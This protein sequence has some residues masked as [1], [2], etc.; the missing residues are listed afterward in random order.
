M[1]SLALLSLLL[2]LLFAAASCSAAAAAAVA[3]GRGKGGLPSLQPFWLLPR[4]PG[5]SGQPGQ[6]GR[7]LIPLPAQT[8][9]MHSLAS[10]GGW[11]GAWQIPVAPPLPKGRGNRRGRR[12]QVST[13]GEKGSCCC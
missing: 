4:P 8:L 6:A 7:E 2:L 13:R 5:H 11:R 3:A 9:L 10:R 12:G 1:M